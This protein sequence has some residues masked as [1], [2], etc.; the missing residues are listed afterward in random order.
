[1]ASRRFLERREAGGAVEFPIGVIPGNALTLADVGGI[2]CFIQNEWTA[3]GGI[4]IQPDAIEMHNQGVSG[5]RALDV[6]R[7]SERIA[8]LGPVDALGIGAA[9]VHR[10]GLHGVAG[11]DV[12]HRC[13]LAGKRM[14]KLRGLEVVGARGHGGRTPGI[15]AKRRSRQAKESY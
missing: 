1:M 9:G 10:P 13:D 3:D 8:A 11:V 15:L 4:P 12:Q 5:R 14:L 7:A 2:E 6:E